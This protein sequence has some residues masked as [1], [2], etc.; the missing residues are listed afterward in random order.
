MQ[1]TTFWS[2]EW[3][4]QGKPLPG[5]SGICPR[6]SNEAISTYSIELEVI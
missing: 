4:R 1:I 6:R 2:K 5:F 3:D